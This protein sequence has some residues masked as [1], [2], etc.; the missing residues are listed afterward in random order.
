MW[1]VGSQG[2]ACGLRLGP[3]GRRKVAAGQSLWQKR[4]QWQW[5]LS[6]RLLFV[7]RL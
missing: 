3:E 2:A 6:S 4:L 5:D 7:F 1:A